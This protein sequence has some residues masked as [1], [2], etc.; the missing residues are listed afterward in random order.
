[1][2][3]LVETFENRSISLEEHLTLC[4][5]R[6]WQ[7]KVFLVFEEVNVMTTKKAPAKKAAPAAKAAPKKAAPKKK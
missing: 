5:S 7:K 4:H 6:R 2:L 1:M 3:L